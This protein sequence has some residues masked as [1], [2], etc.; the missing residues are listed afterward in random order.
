M[1]LR[2]EHV[3]DVRTKRLVGEHDERSRRIASSRRLE[4]RGRTVHRDVHLAQRVDELHRRRKVRLVRRDD[5][6]RA[7]RAVPASAASPSAM[8]SASA[9]ASCRPPPAARQRVDPRRRRRPVVAAPPLDRPLPHL[10]DVE[11]QVLAVA[12]RVVEHAAVERHRIVHR[13][14][15]APFLRRDRIRQVAA[16]NLPLRDERN[17][18]RRRAA[19]RLGQDRDDVVEVAGVADAAVPPAVVRAA[20]RHRRARLPFGGEPLVH[21]RAERLQAEDQQRIEIVVVGIALRRRPHDRARPDR[22]GGGCRE[23]AAATRGRARD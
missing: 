5:V 19:D 10:V 22:S 2:L 21:V 9:S 12:R 3:D 8:A 23:S 20:R 4:R 16:G 1:I 17:A 15:E 6:T 11:Q 14:L 13:L 7:D 18:H